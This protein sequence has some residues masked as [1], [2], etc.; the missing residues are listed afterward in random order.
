MSPI[1]RIASAL[2]FAASFALAPAP[3]LAAE[4]SSA[5]KALDDAS[6]ALDAAVAK[7]HAAIDRA[8]K[9]HVISKAEADKAHALAKKVH[10]E[11]SARLARDAKS[12]AAKKPAKKG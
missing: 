10:A 1:A 2:T 11:V 4:T 3:A 5:P 8:A 9:E 7:A 6:H 12:K